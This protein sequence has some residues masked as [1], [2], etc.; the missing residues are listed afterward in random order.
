MLTVWSSVISDSSDSRSF[1]LNFSSTDLNLT[2]TSRAVLIIMLSYYYVILLQRVSWSISDAKRGPRTS[3]TWKMGQVA[4]IS[5]SW[6]TNDTLAA[7]LRSSAREEPIT[8]RIQRE[9]EYCFVYKKHFLYT[10][11]NG[12]VKIFERHRKWEE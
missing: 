1:F 3:S 7:T 11:N 2:H 6:W 4:S 8:W 10:W 5:K 12:F 9:R